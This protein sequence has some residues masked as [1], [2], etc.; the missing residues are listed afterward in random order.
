MRAF[1]ALSARPSRLALHCGRDKDF[2]YAW[3]SPKKRDER[4]TS[5]D[6]FIFHFFESNIGRQ[7]SW[8]TS[9]DMRHIGGAVAVVPDSVDLLAQSRPSISIQW[10]IVTAS[11][12][13]GITDVW[14][15]RGPPLKNSGVVMF[16]H[17]VA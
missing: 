10:L 2:L 7:R 8:K 13:N 17:R 12:A 9:D 5:E 6:F 3:T 14:D 4:R 11:F 15:T 16:Y 1:R